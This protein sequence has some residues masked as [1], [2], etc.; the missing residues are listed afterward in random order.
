MNRGVCYAVVVFGVGGLSRLCGSAVSGSA[1]VWHGHAQHG[2]AIARTVNG[3]HSI[4]GTQSVPLCVE[5]GM[6]GAADAK[7]RGDGCHRGSSA[8]A[9]AAARFLVASVVLASLLVYFVGCA[10]IIANQSMTAWHARHGNYR[11]RS[12]QSVSRKPLHMIVSDRPVLG[13][14]SVDRTGRFTDYAW[15]GVFE[16]DPEKV[17]AATEFRNASEAAFDLAPWMLDFIRTECRSD[18]CRAAIVS[19]GWP[20]R[21]V[22][23]GRENPRHGRN[24]RVFGAVLGMTIELEDEVF[25]VPC[26]I[27]WSGFARNM[28]IAVPLCAAGLAVSAAVRRRRALGRVSAGR[29]KACGYEL[30]METPSKCHECGV[31]DPLSV[32]AKY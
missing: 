3:K 15:M 19:G 1:S 6:D 14:I 10:S 27:L 25:G 7:M 22:S 5:F 26:R 30:G 17:Q 9:F 23:I 24:N 13:H 20:W 29:C 8:R 16:S 28:A 4:Q 11:Y 12:P 18:T 31:D 32:G 21:C 2:Y